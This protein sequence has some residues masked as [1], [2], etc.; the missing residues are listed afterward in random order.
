MV[1]S[2]KLENAKEDE[3]VKLLHTIYG[4][5]QSTLQF[6]KKLLNGLKNMGFK[7]GYPD[8]CLM[9]INNVLGMI[10]I[11]L[12]VDDFLCIGDK[13]AIASLEK[14]LV[15]AGLQVKPP[16]ELSNYL[17]WKININ[18]E[19]GSAIFHQGRLIKN[20]NKL[21]GEQVKGL[22]TYKVPGTPTVGLVRPTDKNEVVSK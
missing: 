12:Y 5:V 16:E 13:D 15:N 8:P 10:F 17:I 19:E 22:T 1:F 9:Q 11:A 18:K 2:Q 20:L 14:E 4:L 3:C 7:G 6:W 21:Y